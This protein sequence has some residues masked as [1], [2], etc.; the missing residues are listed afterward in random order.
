MKKIWILILCLALI[1]VGIYFVANYLFYDISLKGVVPAMKSTG[2]DVK[3]YLPQNSKMYYP[4]RVSSGYKIDVFANMGRNL[5]RAFVFDSNGTLLVSSTTQGKVIALPDKDN[6]CKADK[7]VEVISNLNKPHGIAFDGDELYVAQTNK[8]VKYAYNPTDYLA[9]GGEIIVTLPSGG[10][11]STRTIRIYNDKLYISVGSSVEACVERY[12]RRATILVSNLDGSELKVF[13][14]GLRNTVFFTFDVNG[15][16]WGTDMGRDDLGDNLP[17]DELN[18]ISEGKD[19]GWPYCY[20]NR[21]RDSK[22][23]Q[24]SFCSNTEPPIYNFPAHVAPLGLT[25]IKSTQ[26]SPTGDNSLLVS[27]HGSTNS[28][29]L[30]GYKIIYLPV[31]AGSVGESSKLLTGFL[32]EKDVLGRPVDLI[33]DTRGNLYI[34]DDYAG[35]VYIYGRE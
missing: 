21:V 19:Y 16:M 2:K 24:N 17:P 20:G 11:H 7:Q 29:S 3:Q 31:F 30:V 9:T 13:A 14:K 23:M 4:F 18:L 22:F 33:F 27:F 26:F 10:R 5:P 25:F 15:N 8:V 32:Q 28:N 34:S 1:G 35:L 6:N 12:G